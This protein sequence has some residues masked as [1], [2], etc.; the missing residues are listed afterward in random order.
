MKK[1]KVSKSVKADV[2]SIVKAINN[3]KAVPLLLCDKNGIP[4]KVWTPEK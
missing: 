4:L 3:N 1:V 2:Q